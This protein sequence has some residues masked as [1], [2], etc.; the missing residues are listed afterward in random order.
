MSGGDTATSL[1]T[2]A[3]AD[4]GHLIALVETTNENDDA[5]I[6]LLAQVSINKLQALL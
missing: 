3:I 6:S 4:L 1:K 5:T 2:R